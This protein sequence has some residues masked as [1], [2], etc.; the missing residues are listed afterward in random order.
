M[1]ASKG[2]SY[3]SLKGGVAVRLDVVIT[4][5]LEL[6]LLDE[7]FEGTSDITIVIPDSVKTM[8]GWTEYPSELVV[9]CLRHGCCH[10]H[11]QDVPEI[12]DLPDNYSELTS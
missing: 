3:T 1:L 12:M 5:N 7:I 11:Q 8:L 2:S 4:N 10:K 6:L 9:S